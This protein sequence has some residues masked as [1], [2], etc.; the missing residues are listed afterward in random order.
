MNLTVRLMASLLMLTSTVVAVAA[1]PEM[2]APRIV[3]NPA[4]YVYADPGS[5]MRLNVPTGWRVRAETLNGVRQLR[6]VPAKADQ[7]ERAAIDVLVRIRPCVGNDALERLAEKFRQASGDREAAESVRLQ[8]AQ[9]RLVVEY[10]EGSYVSNP[11]WIVRH[12]LSVYQRIDRRFL[13]EANCAANA[14]EYKTYRHN[15]E[16]ICFSATAGK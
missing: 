4:F 9:G 8:S 15:L 14:S 6:I 10:R 5:R 12:H 3:K 11:L 16:T 2:H 7:R 13:L 1:P